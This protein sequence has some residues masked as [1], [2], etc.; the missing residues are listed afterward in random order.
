[1]NNH[2]RLAFLGAAHF[3]CHYFLLIFPTAVLAIGRDWEIDYAAALTLGT[4][5]YLCFALGT[6]PAG[7]LGDHWDGDRMIGLSFLGCAAGAVCTALAP[8]AGTLMVGLGIVGVFSAV[9]HPVGLS[10]V[11]RIS[12]RPGRALALNGVCGNLG[13]AGAS[14]GTAILADNFG[15][16]SAFLVPGALAGIAGVVYLRLGSH[17]P[18]RRGTGARIS[19]AV[20]PRPLQIR[21]AGLVL[22][23]ALFSGFVFNGVSIS[24]PRL[25]AERLG[26]HGGLSAVGGYSALVFAVAAF[27]QLPTGM[28]LDR[29]G[30]RPVLATL[31]TLEVG[32][33]VMTSQAVGLAIVPSALTTVTLM[34]AGI[35][36]SAWLLG[37]YVDPSWRSRALAAEYVLSLGMG[38][39]IVPVMAALYRAG[40][41]LDRQYLLFACSAAVVAVG[42]LAIPG[43]RRRRAAPRRT[44]M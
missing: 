13:L 19:G 26:G 33:L 32:A 16:R 23:A 41:G 34:F 20:F 29:V 8:D 37:N 15:W 39:L 3:G 5:L 25:L 4:P 44:A 2:G 27:A 43:H 12:T 40:V 11:T 42:A 6:L 35:P 17:S 38:S 9:Y 21:V 31:F 1:M 18:T 24:L 10:M 30:G 14:L 22:F 36:V 28:L 7:W